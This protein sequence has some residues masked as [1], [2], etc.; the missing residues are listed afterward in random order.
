MSMTAHQQDLGLFQTINERHSVRNYDPEVKISEEE[1]NEILEAATKAPSSWN[2]QHWK[3]LVIDDEKKKEELLPIA[4]NQQQVVDSSAVIAILGDLKANEN[5][6]EVYQGAVEN[7]FMP[8]QVKDTLVG[9]INNAY[10]GDTPFPRDE[11]VLNASLASMN[12]MLAAK[13]K[14]YDTCPMGGFQR[15]KFVEQFNVPERYVPVMLLT[16]GKAA[17]PAHQSARFELDRV[18]VKNSF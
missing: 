2:L 4:Y 8:E 10:E 18:V 11:A 5:A 13:A 7:G 14:G 1:I 17:K 12:L 6:E 15:G 3:F 9:Q 16:V